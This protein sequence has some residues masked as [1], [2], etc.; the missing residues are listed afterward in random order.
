MG[1]ELLLAI[2]TR[3]AY[4][5]R[6]LPHP[7][8]FDSLGSISQQ[9][10]CYRPSNSACRPLFR[11]SSTQ[12]ESDKTI[13]LGR[14]RSLDFDSTR[15][16]NPPISRSRSPPFARR[17]CRTVRLENA[18]NRQIGL[19]IC[20]NNCHDGQSETTLDGNRQWSDHLCPSIGEFRL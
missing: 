4:G 12:R 14:R 11:S 8:S 1:P 13:V 2:G 17:R 7:S 19:F 20:P 15:F 5:S 16:F 10:G 3:S 6:P 18:R 9:S